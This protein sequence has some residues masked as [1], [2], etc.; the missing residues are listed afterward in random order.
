MTDAVVPASAAR[1]ANG[2]TDGSARRATIEVG[3][4]AIGSPREKKSALRMST[5]A[6]DPSRFPATATL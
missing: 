3:S 1:R 2:D 6:I 4:C 5:I